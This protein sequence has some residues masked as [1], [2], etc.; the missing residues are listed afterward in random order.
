MKERIKIFKFEASKVILWRKKNEKDMGTKK[1][2]KRQEA[3]F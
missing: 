1:I 2:L 3:L